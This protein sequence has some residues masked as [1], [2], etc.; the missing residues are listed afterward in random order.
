MDYAS[1]TPPL[2]EVRRFLFVGF[3]ERLR[4]RRPASAGRQFQLQVDL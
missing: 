1:R 2:S 4:A 3:L